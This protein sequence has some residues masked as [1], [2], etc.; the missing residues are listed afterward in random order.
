MEIDGT[1]YAPYLSIIDDLL[2]SV[3]R[4]EWTR[5]RNYFQ[6]SANSPVNDVTDPALACGISPGAPRIKAV[7]RAGATVKASWTDIIPMHV[8]PVLAYMARTDSGKVNS[9]NPNEFSWFKVYHDGFDTETGLWANER[10]KKNDNMYTF[11]IPSDIA[12]GLYTIRTELIAL[13]GNGAG[14]NA[15]GVGGNTMGGFQSYAHCFNVMVT[16]NGTQNPDGVQFP[17]GYSWNDQGIMFYPFRG[18]DR[19]ERVAKNKKYVCIR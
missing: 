8:G 10:V 19:S 3:K 11:K 9:S 7:A 5:T 1:T 4:I 2:P 15:A 18:P 17:G 16:G 14:F 12:S 13:H 6:K